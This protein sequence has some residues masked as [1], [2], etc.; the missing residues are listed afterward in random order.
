MGNSLT[1]SF[2]ASL[3]L[4]LLLIQPRRYDRRV[5]DVC[6]CPPIRWGAGGYRSMN[7]S[8]M[9]VALVLVVTPNVTVISENG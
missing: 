5:A 4:L 8:Q 9:L 6:V 7:G 3:L 1:D 2:F